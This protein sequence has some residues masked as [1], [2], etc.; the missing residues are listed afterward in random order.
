MQSHIKNVN[1]VPP[2]LFAAASFSGNDTIITNVIVAASFKAILYI[3]GARKTLIHPWKRGQKCLHM[4]RFWRGGTQTISRKYQAKN[5]ETNRSKYL[6]WR[7][8]HRASPV[9][10]APPLRPPMSP[11][12]SDGVTCIRST[13]CGRC[14]ALRPWPGLL[15][16]A[17]GLS[18]HRMNNWAY[19]TH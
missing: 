9:H 10:K 14:F 8:V 13:G 18:F 19:G 1:N 4:G 15:T 7:M 12:E 16:T 6:Y 3:N 5:Y 11:T 17:L 2:I